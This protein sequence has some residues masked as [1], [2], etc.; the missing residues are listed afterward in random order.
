M[1]LPPARAVH[2]KAHVAM[3]QWCD[4]LTRVLTLRSA[5][6]Q[7]RVNELFFCKL[8]QT[9]FPALQHGIRTARNVP[10]QKRHLAQADYRMADSSSITNTLRISCR[11]GVGGLVHQRGEHL[12]GCRKAKRLALLSRVAIASSSACENIDRSVPLGRYWR[13]RPLVFSF[14]PRCH[15]ACGSAK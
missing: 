5:G 9:L 4:S 10:V 6:Y 1:V 13:S 12:I 7:T 3:S 8:Y 11:D 2:E 15:G 14:V